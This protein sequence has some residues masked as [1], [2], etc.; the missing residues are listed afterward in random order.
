MVVEDPHLKQLEA[1]V[2]E[3]ERDISTGNDIFGTMGDSGTIGDE[4]M[5]D[6][7]GG[8]KKRGLAEA[9]AK[10]S[11]EEGAR[12]FFILK[13]CVEQAITQIGDNFGKLLRENRS[14]DQCQ[15]EV[16]KCSGVRFASLTQEEELKIVT[17]PNDEQMPSMGQLLSRKKAVEGDHQ[18]LQ[19]NELTCMSPTQTLHCGGRGCPFSS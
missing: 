14:K 17:S 16:N 19:K 15:E 13:W 12:T 4:D 6:A 2:E 11:K 10:S 3:G 9:S 8:K 7:E 1:L 18:K 5:G